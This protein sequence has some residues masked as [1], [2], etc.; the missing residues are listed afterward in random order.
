MIRGVRILVVDDEASVR[1]ALVRALGMEGYE[2]R[3]VGDGAT[4]LTEV[5]QWQPEVVVLDVLMP[6]MDGLTT[7]R[8]LR[9]RGDRTPILM[10]TARDAV[11]DR[12]EGLDA[13]ADDYLVKPFDLDELLARVRALV[14]RTYPEDGAVLST[15]DLVLDTAAHTVRRGDREIELSRTEF[16]LLEVLLRNAGQALPR[17]TLIDRVWGHNSSN[18]LEVYIR[19]LRRKLEADGEAPLIHTVRGV[20]YRLGSS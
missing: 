6:F 2:A 14:R 15:G 8:T 13:G 19:Y 9:G 12:I 16:A 18:A 20:G 3:G 7:C 17:E 4:A 11:A 5:A 10:L 1:D